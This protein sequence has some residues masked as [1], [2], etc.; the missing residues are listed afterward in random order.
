MTD[1]GTRQA[2]FA[3]AAVALL[4]VICVAV[5]IYLL[6]ATPLT[7]AQLVLGLV[8]QAA[9]WMTAIA[10]FWTWLE[11]RVLHPLRVLAED[12]DLMVHGNAPSG[13]ELPAGHALGRLPN[14]LDAL[15]DELAR[16]RADTTKAM[17][18]AFAGGTAQCTLGGDSAGPE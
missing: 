8:I 13:T 17:D 4:L 2:R 15:G 11:T 3:L 14:A 6:M 9:L 18:A 7:P 16:A 10:V 1:K 12:M 5:D